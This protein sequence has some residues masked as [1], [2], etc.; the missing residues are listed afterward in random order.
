MGEEYGE[1]GPFL[2]FTD[3]ED[4]ALRKAVTRG[5]REEFAAFGWR[6]AVPDP[7]DPM[8]YCRSRLA[9]DVQDREP[10]AWLW[11]Y[12]KA[13]LAMRRQYPALGVGGKRRLAAQVKD[14]KVMVVLRR[15]RAGATVLALLNFASE[16]RSVS[17]RL[18]PGRWRRV[19]DS[20]EER[21]GGP[22][23]KASRL[24]SVSRNGNAR[25]DMAPL[26]AAVF[27]RTKA[28]DAAGGTAAEAT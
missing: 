15:D 2:F 5:R 27:L 9:W 4:P 25:V 8:S 1:P 13:L 11:Q 12:Y 28:T 14:K 7:Q 19:L 6:G 26:G 18:P 21:F 16:A 22:G 3:F 20:G 17:L 23:P 10:H 24:L